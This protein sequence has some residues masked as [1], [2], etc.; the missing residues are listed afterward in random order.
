MQLS[1]RNVLVIFDDEMQLSY[2]NMFWYCQETFQFKHKI[3]FTMLLLLLLC[4]IVLKQ[5]KYSKLERICECVNTYNYCEKLFWKFFVMR[6][7]FHALIVFDIAIVHFISNLKSIL[8]CSCYFCLFLILLKQ[9]KFSQLE[10]FVS[11]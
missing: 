6:C 1:R 11:V 3:Y 8:L 5:K 7:N 4:L 2:T 9:N 10:G